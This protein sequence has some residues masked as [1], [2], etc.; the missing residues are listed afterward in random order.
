L[1][2]FSIGNKFSIQPE[3]LYSRQKT[4]STE[5]V[6]GGPFPKKE[7]TLDYIQIP[8]LAK[9]YIYKNVSL[10]LGPSFNF[11]LKDKVVNISNNNQS[12]SDFAEKTEFSGILGISYKLN[13]GFFTSV[14][15]NK[16]LSES[17]KNGKNNSFQI[18]I[19]YMF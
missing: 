11:L 5:I 6:Y 19:G 2:E 13:N 1:T 16:G 18:G 14:R 12:N 4:N 9:F 10:E 17:I 7:Y 3:I 15:Y 8:V